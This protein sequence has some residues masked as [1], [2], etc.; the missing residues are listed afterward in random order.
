M[1]NRTDRSDGLGLVLI[2]LAGSLWA[3]VPDPPAPAADGF[4]R[5]NQ[6]RSRT[7]PAL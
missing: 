3:Q 2:V 4:A 5:S 6:P 1:R 7:T